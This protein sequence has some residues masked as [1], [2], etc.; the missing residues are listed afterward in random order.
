[1]GSSSILPRARALARAGLAALLL[2]G[3]GER[4]PSP[5]VAA[6]APPDAPNVVL[7][8]MDGLRPDHL[9]AFG[10]ERETS[11]HI[12]SLARRGQ[13]FSRIIPSSCS[14]KGSLTSLLTGL[15]NPRHGLQSRKDVLPDEA[16]TLAEVFQAHGYQTAGFVASPWISSSFHF[17]QGFEKFEDF[18]DWQSEGVRADMVMGEANRFLWSRGRDERRPF[19]LYLHTHEPHPPWWGGSPWLVNAGGEKSFFGQSCGYIASDAERDSLSEADR[20][21]LVARYDGSIYF[22]DAWFGG[23][24]AT[25]ERL[26]MLRRTVIAVSADHGMDLLDHYMG[27]HGYAPYDSVTRGFLVL[28]DGRSEQQD[29]PPNPTQGRIFDIGPT[30]LGLAGIEPPPNLDG[31]D[32]LRDGARL[33]ELAFTSCYSGEVVR[34]PEWKLIRFE[35]VVK[36]RQ[37]SWPRGVPGEWQLVELASD[38]AEAHDASSA[39]P[40]VR[41]GLERALAERGSGTEPTGVA[42]QTLE[43]LDPRVRQRL[44]ELGY[45]K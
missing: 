34:S 11:R 32:L 15:D 16:L 43:E 29:A 17:Q 5:P 1:M 28:Y 7:F 22:A 25:L 23:L 31:L 6:A 42:P 21:D 30:L 20:H 26:G 36:K 27:G 24:L 45:V 2:A 38:P 44:R 39:R 3:C 33:P 37:G 13:R 40:D 4:A 41:Q 19:F 9:S 35:E 14:T 18:L 8:T 12:D 10:Y